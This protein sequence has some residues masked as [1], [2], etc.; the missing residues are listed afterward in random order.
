MF[1]LSLAGVELKE[2]NQLD[3]QDLRFEP[4]LDLLVELSATSV[5]F[6]QAV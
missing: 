5:F 6:R 4:I 1:L 2:T 3:K